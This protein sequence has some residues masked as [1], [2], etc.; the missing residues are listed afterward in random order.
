LL[1]NLILKAVALAALFISK[2]LFWR[3]KSR[4]W[5]I[6]CGG[7]RWGDNAD[8][9]WRY[10][11][12]E[13]PEI[14]TLAIVK[15]E[16]SNRKKVKR[17]SLR[18]YIL[19]NLAEVLAVTHSL[20]DIGPDIVIVQ[21]KAKKIWLQH[22]VIGI[23]RIAASNA[24]AGKYDLICAS[25]QKE[26]EIMVNELGIKTDRIKITGLARHDILKEKSELE[27]IRTGILYMPTK[28][29]WIDPASKEYYINMLFSWVASLDE[30]CKDLQVKL[31]LHPGWHQVGLKSLDLDLYNIRY[32]DINHDPQQLICES[33][34]LIT[35]YSSV[36]FDAALSGIPTIFY[37]PDRSLFIKR[38]KLFRDFV[39]QD[40]LLIVDN[41][42][43][44]LFE[45][46]RILNEHSY[47]KYRLSQDKEWASLYVE[48][49]D[50]KSCQS[51]YD[52]ITRLPPSGMN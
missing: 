26:K 19:I 13:H 35:D 24:R 31:W 20:S 23:K 7:E 51:I 18:N 34:L 5:L 45:A 30:I 33:K 12:R 10:M 9:L 43:D 3:R 39:E 37:Q 42:E 47:F 21:T 14:E 25:S 48:T 32:F 8:A 50:G 29:D 27:S 16:V 44:L 40:L 6:A 11:N 15:S 1:K 28:R 17:N 2:L 41:E 36:F 4:I 46:N 38:N 52:Q 22:G 49:F